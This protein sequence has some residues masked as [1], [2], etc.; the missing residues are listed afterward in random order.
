MAQKTSEDLLGR[1]LVL[2]VC[3]VGLT[4]RLPKGLLVRVPAS[5][6]PSRESRGRTKADGSALCLRSL[7]CA[8]PG[9]VVGSL[10]FPT[11]AVYQVS[12]PFVLC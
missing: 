12:L 11:K 1:D 4:S 8:V 2:G 7:A 9:W 5:A 3:P 10:L 6:L